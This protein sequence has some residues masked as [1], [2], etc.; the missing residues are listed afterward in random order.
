MFLTPFLYIC[1]EVPSV[2]AKYILKFRLLGGVETSIFIQG[3]S[4]IPKLTKP[5]Q[6]P[7]IYLRH[8][9]NWI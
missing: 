6:N 1:K 8:S 4:L 5:S 7:A 9:K 2:Q 3:M